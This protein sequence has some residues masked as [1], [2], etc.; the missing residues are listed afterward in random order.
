MIR[1]RTTSNPSKINVN[2]GGYY[3]NDGTYS[4]NYLSSKGLVGII[5]HKFLN[6]GEDYLYTVMNINNLISEGN[7]YSSYIL[8]GADTTQSLRLRSY[9]SSTDLSYQTLDDI[10][11]DNYLVDNSSYL[12]YWDSIQIGS[13]TYDNWAIRGLPYKQKL[14]IL[15][16]KIGWFYP[17]PITVWR[18]ICNNLS[19]INNKLSISGGDIINEGEYYW[20]AEQYGLGIQWCVIPIADSFEYSD[21]AQ[22]DSYSH[23]SLLRC[24][25][26]IVPASINKI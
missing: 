9:G 14:E 4:D 3:Y 6:S 24:V 17:I 11:Y 15:G 21:A 20:S 13:N 18:S 12:S 26:Y 7:L 19:L 23:R 25:T 22:V 8:A 10:L 16:V 1:R 5:V 2:L